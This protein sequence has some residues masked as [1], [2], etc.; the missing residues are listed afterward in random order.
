MYGFDRYRLAAS[1]VRTGEA[2]QVTSL[3]L[4]VLLEC[5]FILGGF[6][7]ARAN[8]DCNDS[9]ATAFARDKRKQSTS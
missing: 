4:C 9:L 8:C 5:M 2:S 7:K 1:S 3:D 6:N